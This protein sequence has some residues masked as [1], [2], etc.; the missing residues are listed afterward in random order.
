MTIV[1][2]YGLSGSAPRSHKLDLHRCPSLSI[3]SS[4]TSDNNNSSANNS[5]GTKSGNK[6]G[7][8]IITKITNHSDS[9][10][11]GA[12]PMRRS[13]KNGHIDNASDSFGSNQN[14]SVF[15]SIDGNESQDSNQTS[16][17]DELLTAPKVPFGWDVKFDPILRQYYYVNQLENLVQ[18]D[19]PEEVLS[20]VRFYGS[21]DM[22]HS[23]SDL[24]DLTNNSSTDPIYNFNKYGK[25]TKDDVK[26]HEYTISAAHDHM[27][28]A[29]GTGIASEPKVPTKSKNKPAN[30]KRKLSSLKRPR[31]PLSSDNRSATNESATSESATS[32]S[33]IG[34]NAGDVSPPVSPVTPAATPTT[35]N[36]INDDIQSTMSSAFKFHGTN[37]GAFN[38]DNGDDYSMVSV[39]SNDMDR[40]S[41]NA[42]NFYSANKNNNENNN[43]NEIAEIR[44]KMLEEVKNYE[45]LRLSESF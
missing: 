11:I 40:S 44:R 42:Y 15:S 37:E 22:L 14:D 38:A 35:E 43:R 39:I 20:P 6:K 13:K 24:S 27:L 33:A 12:I 9:D 10:N 1:S 21:E 25:E 8:S 17:T 36:I 16:S 28:L 29:N 45:A 31:S 18:L 23:G 32:Q 5:G 2:K 19:H 7:L 26:T 4:K 34:Q 3:F 41:G 30:W